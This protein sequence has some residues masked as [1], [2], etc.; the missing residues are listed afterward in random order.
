[1][2]GKK[3]LIILIFLNNFFVEGAISHKPTISKNRDT[4]RLSSG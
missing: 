4:M 1:M 2:L 3:A